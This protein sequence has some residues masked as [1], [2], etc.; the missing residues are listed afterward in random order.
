MKKT[1]LWIRS[2]IFCPLFY[3]YALLIVVGML[4]TFVLPVK[5]MLFVPEWWCKG[6]R[7]LL[8]WVVGIQVNVKGLENLPKKQGYI[9]AAKH[10]SA[11]ETVLLH[12]MVPNAI[13]VLKESLLFLPVAGWYFLKTGCIAVN[14]K[15]GTK[16]LRKM[17]SISQKRLED[18]FNIIIFPE[19]TR[20][21]VGS[22]PKY[23]SGVA[24]VYEQCQVPVVPLALD[25]GC[26]WPKNSFKRFAG[27]ATFEF[28]KPI[29]PGLDKKIFLNRLENQIEN[30]TNKLLDNVPKDF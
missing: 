27:T 1:V 19:G 2:L 7:F 15:K 28:L 13:Y 10:Q 6:N 25:T 5:K 16:S 14:R 9:V 11:M 4:W 29:E 17:L 30:A 21:P 18:G 20:R 24:L 23:N 26:F 12:M 8:R 3:A 22:A